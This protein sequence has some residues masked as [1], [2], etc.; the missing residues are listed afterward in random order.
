MFIFLI[1]KMIVITIPAFNE[2]RTIGPV[3]KSIKQAMSGTNYKYKILVV[4]DGSRDG[5]VSIAKA[6]GAIVKSHQTNQG[7]AQT[8]R[9][10]MSECL[11]LKADVIVHTD[12]DGQYMASDIP[13]LIKKVEEGYDLVLGSRFKGKI[14]Y[15]PFM[16]RFGN[17][18]FSRV[19]SKIAHYNFSD[20]QTGFRAFKSEVAEKIHIISDYTYTQEQLIKAVRQNFKIAEVPVYFKTRHGK[21]RLM[22][23]PFYYAMRAWITIFRIYRDYEPLKFFG[24]AGLGLMAIGFVIGLY[25]LYN[26]I[27]TGNVGHIPLTVLSMLLITSGLQ[28]VLF[29]FLA[30]MQKR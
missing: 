25:L 13:A 1:N 22:K 26:F 28:V 4:D 20:C 5:T 24:M 10:E 14:E 21:S 9:T 7:L 30:D 12:A 19:I 8:F 17:K 18:A 16:K 29:G 11:Q 6:E 2:A 15:M 3:L 23:N 27:V